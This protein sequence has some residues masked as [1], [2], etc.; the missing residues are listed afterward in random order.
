MGK[1]Y[2]SGNEAIVEGAIRA[3]CRYYA[4]YPITPSTEIMERI[5]IR[6]N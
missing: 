4:G 3:G 5:S 1:Y 2:V 6:F